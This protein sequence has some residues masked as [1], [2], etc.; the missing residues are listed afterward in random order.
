MRTNLQRIVL[1]FILAASAA[2]VSL[3]PLRA[4]ASEK[5]VKARHPD[6]ARLKQHLVEHVKYP[7]TRA[8][9]LAACAQTTEFSK[10]EK[11]WFAAALPEGSYASADDVL[12][13]IK[14]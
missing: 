3:A 2:T 9:I 4:A 13:A 1:G 12:K 7:A 11:A 6:A 10:A 14:E 5:T 8:E